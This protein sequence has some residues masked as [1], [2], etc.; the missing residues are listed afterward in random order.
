M[1]GSDRPD[2]SPTIKNGPLP[3]DASGSESFNNL[4]LLAFLIAVPTYVN[5]KTGGGIFIWC[6]LVLLASVPILIVFWSV[7]SRISPRKNEKVRFP[8]KPVE[9]YLIFHEP[10][11][12]ALYRGR[13]KIPM[14]TFHEM[15]FDG[16]VDFNGDP[17]DVMEYRH[18]WANF[19]FTFGL[20]RFFLT[21]MIPE[22]IMHTRS[23]GE[24]FVPFGN[25]DADRFFQTRNRCGTTMIEETTS[26]AGSLGPA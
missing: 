14:E 17:L 22:M 10:K 5:F 8:G 12:Q 18:D 20:F 24:V 21:G 16:L 15:Y 19:R 13:S 3:A 9:S 7:A 23:Q 6:S 1:S 4:L 25:P 2:K 11:A 26:T